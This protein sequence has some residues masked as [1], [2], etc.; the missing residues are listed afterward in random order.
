MLTYTDFFFV[1]KKQA[2]PAL[3]RTDALVLWWKGVF[4]GDAVID[5]ACIPD[6]NQHA[7]AEHAQ[8]A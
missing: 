5:V 6:R 1:Q 8:V 4:K 7:L 2:L 3:P